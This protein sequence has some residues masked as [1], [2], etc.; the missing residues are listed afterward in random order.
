M[1]VF[2]GTHSVHVKT[3]VD[4]HQKTTLEAAV[5]LFPSWDQGTELRSLGLHSKCFYHGSL[6]IFKERNFIFESKHAASEGG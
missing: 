6:R 3:Y 2:V 1:S 5:S 4:A